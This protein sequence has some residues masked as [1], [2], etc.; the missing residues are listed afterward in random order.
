[1]PATAPGNERPPLC[2]A[3]HRCR[4]IRPR[5]AT[6]SCFFLTLTLLLPLVAA[7]QSDWVGT[8]QV[9]QRLA[10]REVVVQTATAMAPTG[11]R[12]RIRAAIRINASPETIWNVIIDC[13]QAVSFVPGL[14]RCLSI[15]RAHDGSWEDIEQEV[16]YSWFLPSI[17]YVFRA[18]YDRFHRI[19][20]RRVSGDLKA[21]EGTW[22]LTRTADASATVVEYEMYLD[23]GFWVPQPL[24]TRSLRKDLPAALRG[25]RERVER[26][27]AKGG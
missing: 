8:A 13:R 26:V 23:P 12:G 21:Q 22:L 24:V 4:T 11:P 17:R 10:A 6:L 16:R 18:E 15:D 9:Q 5:T 14:R 20:F 7:A 1:M 2:T 25:L 27:A 3:T 19:D